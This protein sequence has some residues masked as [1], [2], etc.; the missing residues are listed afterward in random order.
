[1]YEQ[2]L[3][4]R[5]KFAELTSSLGAGVLGAGIGVLL[6]AYL[7]G[8]GVPILVLGLVLHAWGMRDKNVI[9]AGGVQPR[10]SI[11]LYW[12]CW[13]ALAGV[14]VYALGRMVGLT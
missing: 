14:A 8:L 6:A 10:W 3:S 9:E 11:A 5:L 2:A 7:G 4:A 13:L 12:A 1:M